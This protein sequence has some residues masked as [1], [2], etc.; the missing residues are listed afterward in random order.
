M[1]PCTANHSTEYM[2]SLFTKDISR[3][4]INQFEEPRLIKIG[5][6]NNN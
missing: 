5:E 1:I 3:V 2:L 6:I 4:E